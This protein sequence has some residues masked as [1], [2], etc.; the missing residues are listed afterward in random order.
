[1]WRAP[2]ER[3]SQTMAWKNARRVLPT[4]SVQRARPRLVLVLTGRC[5]RERAALRALMTACVQW[6]KRKAETYGVKLKILIA[7]YQA[8]VY[9]PS[10]YHVR[11]PP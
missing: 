9:I 4:I 11:P 3:P 5:R 2:L 8:V 6:L 1:M 7:L 10:V